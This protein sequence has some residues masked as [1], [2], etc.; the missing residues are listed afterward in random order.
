MQR[1]IEPEL[2]D[3]A[4]QAHAYAMADFAGPNERFVG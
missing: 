1:I 4:E 2:M 3:A